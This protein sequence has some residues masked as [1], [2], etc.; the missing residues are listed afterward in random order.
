MIRDRNIEWARQR[1]FIPVAQMDVTGAGVS[2]HSTAPALGELGT[3]DLTD[4][5]MTADDIVTK[6]MFFPSYWDTKQEIG[7]RVIWTAVGNDA[8]T[9]AATWIILY[10][11]VDEDEQIILPATVL[12]VPITALDVY[13]FSTTS[14]MKK[15]SR[16]IINANT[17][18][19][20]A[21][22]GLFTFSVELQAVTTFGADEV[23]L[24]GTLWDYYPRW[25]VGG[26][27]TNK[28]D[29]IN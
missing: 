22:D 7:V 6:T 8:T 5:P 1:E 13:G 14:N 3:L 9:D 16:G 10:D 27:N 12:S 17:F 23:S 11:Q 28:D 24:L 29:R 4:M 20:A 25:T 18:D 19:E 21:L 26:P 15:T 2:H